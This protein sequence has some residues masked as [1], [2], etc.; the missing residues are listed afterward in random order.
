V[1]PWIWL[2]VAAVFDAL[3]TA[4]HTYG[5][6]APADSSPEEKAVTDAMKNFHFDLMGTMR[7]PWEIFRGFSL[8]LTVNLAILAVVI[9][10]LSTV[11]RS[12]PTQTRAVVWA[13]VV[14]QAVISV[15]CWTDFFL[16]PALLSTLAALSLLVAAFGLQKA[17]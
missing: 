4:G 6:F 3:F 10:L 7:T 1:K 17:T 2:R 8:L 16:A 9:W 5:H 11:A 14:G 13:L 15:I 12:S